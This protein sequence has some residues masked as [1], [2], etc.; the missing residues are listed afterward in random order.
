MER[1]LGVIQM[2]Y[3]HRDV[4]IW[5]ILNGFY[6]LETIKKLDSVHDLHTEASKHLVFATYKTAYL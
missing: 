2:S 3:Q 6:M 1:F 5:F 4:L